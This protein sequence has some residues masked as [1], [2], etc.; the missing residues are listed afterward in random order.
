[1]CSS[2]TTVAPA[3][4]MVGWLWILPISLTI[5]PMATCTFLSRRLIIWR[6]DWQPPRPWLFGEFCDSDGF[7][8]SAEIIAANQGE[9]PWW[10]TPD[11]WTHTWRPEVQALLETKERLAQANPGFSAAEL[12]QIANA[13]S[14]MVRKFTLE[15]VRKRAT[16]KGYVITGLRDTPIATSGIFD[17]FDRPKWTPDDFRPFNDDAILCLDV[18]RSRIWQ[19]GGDRAAHLDG[20]NWWA[21]ERVRLHLILN[22]TKLDARAPQT[23]TWQVTQADTLIGAGQATITHPLPLGQPI[24]IGVI[25]F[26]L[27]VTLDATPLTLRAEFSNGAT[28]VCESMAAFLPIHARQVNLPM[29][30]ADPIHSLDAEWYAFGQPLAGRPL[31]AQ[32]AVL[33]TSVLDESVSAYLHSGGAVLLLQQRKGPLPV[34]QGPF[35]REALKLFA[36]HPLWQRFPHPSFADLQ[37]FGLATD[38]MFDTPDLA[39]A[40]PGLVTWTPILRRLDAPRVHQWQSIFSRRRSGQGGLSVA[41]CAY[42]GVQAR[43]RLV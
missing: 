2:V 38:V 18:G 15:A 3:R 27:P 11:I 35:W 10:M 20:Y 28:V 22:A 25:E 17:D 1:M 4:R 42:K 36:P 32:V 7:R 21:G 23:F 34:K 6:R 30:R 19:N 39:A 16:V 40:L 8:D 31:D 9:K 13:Q 29:S 43:S 14:R 26:T 5:T 37:W 33:I 41:P 12:V 24:E